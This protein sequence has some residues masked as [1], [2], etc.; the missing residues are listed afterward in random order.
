[1]HNVVEIKSHPW[2]IIIIA[3]TILVAW[4]VMIMEGG[5]TVPRVGDHEPFRYVADITMFVGIDVNEGDTIKIAIISQDDPLKVYTTEKAR[6]KKDGSFGYLDKQNLGPN[7]RF[8]I[9]YTAPSNGVWGIVIQGCD[10][11]VQFLEPHVIGHIR[12]TF[13]PV[14]IIM[15]TTAIF[16]GWD[17]HNYRR[18]TKNERQRLEVIK[19]TCRCDDCD[20]L[21]SS[22]IKRLENLDYFKLDENTLAWVLLGPSFVGVLYFS[23]RAM[24]TVWFGGELL[25]LYLLVA[26]VLFMMLF[27]CVYRIFRKQKRSD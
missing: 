26:S 16:L 8:V 27:A 18:D 23:I 12:Y 17:Y 7:Q 25:L 11:K 4:T 10:A 24:E 15:I 20:L 9:E 5:D 13:I 1:M 6:I 2:I 14:Y 22:G 19:S 3:A 21:Y